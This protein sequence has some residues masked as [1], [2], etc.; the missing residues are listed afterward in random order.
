MQENGSVTSA[1]CP[2]QHEKREETKPE[3]NTD[4]NH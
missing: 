1:Y 4:G 3:S 2:V